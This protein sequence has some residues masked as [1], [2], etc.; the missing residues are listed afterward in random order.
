MLIFVLHINGNG[1]IVMNLEALMR[2]GVLMIDFMVMIGFGFKWFLI[3]D[4]ST[5]SDRK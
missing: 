3:V 5:Q 4:H 2:L 1:M